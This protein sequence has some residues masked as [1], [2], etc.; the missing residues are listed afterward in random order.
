M[1][2]F[3]NPV[4][5]DDP[6]FGMEAGQHVPPAYA[7]PL[8]PPPGTVSGPMHVQMTGPVAGAAMPPPQPSTNTTV[9]INQPAPM[10]PMNVGPRSWS[11]GV[12]SCCDDMGTC[13]LGTFCP[14]ILAC[15]VA[16]DMNESVCVPCC[17]PGWLIVLRTKLRAENNITGTVMDDCCMVCFCGNC[18]LCQMKREIKYVQTTYRPSS[19]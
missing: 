4:G 8:A 13:L 12:C 6:S 15:Q 16:G 19:F 17:V 2:K 5:D 9:I 11:S 7:P 1:E 3:H 14:C 10:T 18:V